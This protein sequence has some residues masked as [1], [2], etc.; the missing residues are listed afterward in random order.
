MMKSFVLRRHVFVTFNFNSLMKEFYREI[1]ILIFAYGSPRFI[2][3]M[4]DTL[5]TNILCKRSRINNHYDDDLKSHCNWIAAFKT[6]PHLSWREF[7]RTKS[8]RESRMK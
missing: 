8:R 5:M 6:D 2:F 4:F 1:S 3:F 7:L